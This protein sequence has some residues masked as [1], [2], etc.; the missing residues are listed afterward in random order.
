MDSNCNQNNFVE[1]TGD[2]L[3][4]NHVEFQ[5][6]LYSDRYNCTNMPLFF[7][8]ILH[9]VAG[10]VSVVVMKG[11]CVLVAFSGLSMH[12]FISRKFPLHCKTCAIYRME[13]L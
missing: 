12:K 13:V 10:F 6:S 11:L 4:L 3:V 8:I 2:Q 1:T 5:N 9:C 7:Y